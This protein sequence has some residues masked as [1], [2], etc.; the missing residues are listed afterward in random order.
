MKW[1]VQTTNSFSLDGARRPTQPTKLVG[2]DEPAGIVNGKSIPFHVASSHFLTSRWTYS[3]KD[4]KYR[5]IN[6]I[7]SAVSVTHNPI[8]LTPIGQ[9]PLVSRLMKDVHNSGPPEPQYLAVDCI[10]LD[11]KTQQK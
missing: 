7:R 3:E 1:Q 11:Q 9:H 2:Q 8:K 4:K 6:L 5:T 10:K